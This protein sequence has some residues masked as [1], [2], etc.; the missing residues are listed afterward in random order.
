MSHYIPIITLIIDKEKLPSNCENE[1]ELQFQLLNDLYQKITFYK[2]TTRNWHHIEAIRRI[3][4]YLNLSTLKFVQEECCVIPLEKIKNIALEL[5]QLAFFVQDNNRLKAYL[6]KDWNT[7]LEKSKD[8]IIKKYSKKVFENTNRYFQEQKANINQLNSR[9]IY[10]ECEASEDISEYNLQDKY[11]DKYHSFI[12]VLY[13][14]KAQIFI[15]KKAIKEQE[16]VV[17]IMVS[18]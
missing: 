14:L 1:P 12:P 17:H 9:K 10:I 15:T 18:S 13:W 7:D 4:E 11:K 16:D 3:A 2:C 6:L 5:E 8:I